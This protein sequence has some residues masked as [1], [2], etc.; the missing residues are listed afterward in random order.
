MT[1]CEVVEALAR[2]VDRLDP[3][4]TSGADAAR[5]VG[6]FDRVERLGAAGKALM[7][8]RAV[9]CRQWVRDGS[10]SPQEWLSNMSGVPVGAAQRMLATAEQAVAQPEL[11]SALKTGELSAA[12]AAEISSAVADNPAAAGRLL[13]D[14]RTRGSRI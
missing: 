13:R 2:E 14:A 11:A 10:H 1:L 4:R 5:L 9:D 3:A 8:A 12:Q 6:L 7:V